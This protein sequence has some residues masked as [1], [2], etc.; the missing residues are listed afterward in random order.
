MVIEERAGQQH[1][2]WRMK[3]AQGQ[4]LSEDRWPPQ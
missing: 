2:E 4:I 1:P 3:D